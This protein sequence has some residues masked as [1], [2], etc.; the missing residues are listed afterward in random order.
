MPFFISIKTLE[1][2]LWADNPAHL[3]NP[4]KSSGPVYRFWN[5]DHTAL[6]A[7]PKAEFEKTYLFKFENDESITET[8]INN[9]ITA[10]YFLQAGKNTMLARATLLNGG[11]LVESHSY[12]NSADF[13][14]Q[15]AVSA[16]LDKI[17][18][19]IRF[20]LTF[21]LQ[22]TKVKEMPVYPKDTKPQIDYHPFP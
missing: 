16:C 5:E 1:A 3:Y 11:V 15:E 13:N 10:V 17:Y 14:E 9:F 22:C 19:K 4:K 20:L 7:I 6:E 8:D 12:I 18:D 21:L 2:T